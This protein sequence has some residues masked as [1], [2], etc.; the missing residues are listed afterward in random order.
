MNVLQ[1]AFTTL[2]VGK[3]SAPCLLASLY[4]GKWT[5]TLWNFKYM[6]GAW[7]HSEVWYGMGMGI[8]IYLMVA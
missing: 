2:D 1:G 6:S 4:I 7:E 5:T 3:S 8:A